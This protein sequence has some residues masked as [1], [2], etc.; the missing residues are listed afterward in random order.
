VSFEEKEEFAK[1]MKDKG[2]KEIKSRIIK[3]EHE[4]GGRSSWYIGLWQ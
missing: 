3:C 4:C 2:K 1:L